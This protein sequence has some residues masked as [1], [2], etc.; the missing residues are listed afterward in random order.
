MPWSV[1]RAEAGKNS[2]NKDY[3]KD[4]LHRYEP[5]KTEIWLVNPRKQ[6]EEAV[7]NECD[8]QKIKHFG[9]HCLMTIY[10]KNSEGNQ[11]ERGSNSPWQIVL[12]QLLK[13]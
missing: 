5:I 11:R 4:F 6:Q 13:E 12:L 8:I 10:K 1:L 9:R 2:A 3:E 7:E